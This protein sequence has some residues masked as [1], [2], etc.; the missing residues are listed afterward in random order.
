[1][2]E[3]GGACCALAPI[4]PTVNPSS[5]NA[6]AVEIPATYFVERML[7]WFIIANPLH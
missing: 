4:P 1:M 2:R 6:V 5:T 3:C 7:L